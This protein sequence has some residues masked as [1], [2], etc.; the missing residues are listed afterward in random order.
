MLENEESRKEYQGKEAQMEIGRQI[1]VTLEQELP[2]VVYEEIEMREHHIVMP[3]GVKLYAKKWCPKEEGKYPVILMRNPYM[4]NEMVV[5]PF[6][7]PAF[8]KRGYAFLEVHVRGALQ[9]DGE[10]LPFVHERE[11]GRA[12]IDW[13]AEQE[14]CDG[15]IGTF[16]ASY[17]GHTQWCV[18]DYQ[19]PALKTMFISVC[20]QHPYHTFYRR[21]MFRQEVWTAWAA[22]MMGDHRYHF[23]AP[24]DDF[25]LRQKAYAV[26]PQI[27]LGEALIE[28]SCDWYQDWAGNISEESAYWN[29]GFWKELNESVREIKIPLFLHG[30]W[31]DIFLRSQLDSYRKLPEEVRRKSRFLIGPWNHAGVAGGTMSYPGEQAAGM[32]QIK[33]ALEWFD[34]QLKGKEYAYE[35]GVIEGYSIGDSQWK[36]W[37]DDFPSGEGLVFY[38]EKLMDQN[39]VNR[40][41]SSCPQNGQEISYIYDPQNP[42]ESIGGTLLANNRDPMGQPECST[43][44]PQ[45]G[46]RE[47]VVSFVSDV[48]TEDTSINGAMQMNLFVSSSVAATAF[49]VKVMEMYPDGRSMNIRD[50]ITDIRWTDEETEQSYEPEEVRELKFTLLDISWRITSG[51]RLRVDIASSNFPA[52]HVHPNTEQLWIQTTDIVKA[53]QKIWCG[54]MYPSRI[55]LPAEV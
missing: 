23:F 8:A 5:G 2:P 50:D 55:I 54:G 19:H 24:Q 34:H 38:L 49:T 47:D 7:A 53:R 4:S 3:D 17:V 1:A 36:I 12:V 33:A 42:V 11:D 27:R 45:P 35:T 13:I 37:E 39:G 28:E 46:Y 22:Q 51:S 18:A 21:G 6:I 52:Y 25:A 29:S 31:F 16:G 43:K 30:G 26:K 44:Q 40:L 32:F 41:S 15:N 48:F 14:W 9:S 20:G 10:W